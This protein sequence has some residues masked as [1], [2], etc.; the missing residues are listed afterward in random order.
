MCIK[1]K[2]I[3]K[4]GAD[5]VIFQRFIYKGV[6]YE[7]LKGRDSYL[8]VNKLVLRVFFLGGRGSVLIWVWFW[9]GSSE[10]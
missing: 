6:L 5:H 10:G 2:K 7:R 1:K 9:F 8:S 3:E 4:A